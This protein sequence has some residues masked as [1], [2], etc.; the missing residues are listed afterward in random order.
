MS[1]KKFSATITT[2]YGQP[3]KDIYQQVI[4][5]VEKERIAKSRAQLLLVERGLQHTQ[6]PE[7]LIK[8]VKEV[9]EK[10]V[11]KDR[12]PYC[13]DC[14][15]KPKVDKSTPQKHLGTQE[16]VSIEEPIRDDHIRGDLQ[17]TGQRASADKLTTRDKADPPSSS[18]RALKE[19]KSAKEGKGIGGWIALGGFLA[20]IFAPT[21]YR[22]FTK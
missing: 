11:P 14:D 4:D 13:K 10:I 5:L 22:W 6:N 21:V 18:S 16:H 8:T 20:V 3:E 9:V 7:P 2:R 17:N 1:T 12:Y 19:K 15:G